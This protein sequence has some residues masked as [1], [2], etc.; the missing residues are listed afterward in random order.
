MDEPEYPGGQ[1]SDG[2]IVL[3]LL[4]QRQGRLKLEERRL[5]VA[6]DDQ[7]VTG[8][9]PRPD[10]IGPALHISPSAGAGSPE[11]RPGISPH[12]AS[13]AYRPDFTASS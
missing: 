9:H 8:E 6:E 4:S 3:G 11:R 12:A 1:F 13:S 10:V 5:G 7:R 2:L